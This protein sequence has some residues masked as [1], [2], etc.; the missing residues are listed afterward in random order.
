MSRRVS[1]HL[2]DVR[3]AQVSSVGEE[4]A[5]KTQARKA[6]KQQD[7]S[8]TDQRWVVGQAEMQVVPCLAAAHGEQRGLSLREEPAGGEE[9]RTAQQ[10][11][12]K[13]ALTHFIQRE[14]KASGRQR[15]CPRPHS[16]SVWQS[17]DRNPRLLTLSVYLHAPI[18]KC[19]L[20]SVSEVIKAEAQ[21]STLCWKKELKKENSP[22]EKFR[23][24]LF[25][26]YRLARVPAESPD[27]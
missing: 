25:W 11:A 5:T 8:G 2:G 7:Q 15:T 19:L 20:R 21:Q 16:Q 4:E 10:L 3:A 6:K 14:V 24:Q 13:K 18:N 1:T 23:K 9:G 12:S 22:G 26:G 27:K 17:Q